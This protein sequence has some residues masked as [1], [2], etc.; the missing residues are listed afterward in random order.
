M[1]E[2]SNSPPTNHHHTA[3]R[4][5]H[6][7]VVIEFAPESEDKLWTCNLHTEV[8][9]KYIIPRGKQSPHKILYTHSV[10]IR[11]E[12][13]LYQGMFL[14][15]LTHEE[16]GCF[17]WKLI[18]QKFGKVPSPRS[19]H[20]AWAYKGNLWVFG[21]QGYTSDWYLHDHGEFDGVCNNQLLQFSTVSEVWT[22]PKCHG[23]VPKP[24]CEHSTTVVG[25]NVWLFSGR[26]N[27]RG[28]N[29]MTSTN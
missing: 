3:V 18:N 19:G 7:I 8:W 5:D 12:I 6:R 1:E 27:A 21:G 17:A 28:P 24:R 14:W 26:S 16:N 15:K 9:R 2:M 4:L 22:N 10:V 11:G 23:E 20:T 13:H 25:D 29:L